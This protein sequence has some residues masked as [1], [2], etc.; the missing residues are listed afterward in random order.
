MEAQGRPR[1]RR[2]PATS[3]SGCTR[4][5]PTRRTTSRTRATSTSN[6][7]GTARG[8]VH[9]ADRSLG[10]RRRGVQEA[11]SG[12]RLG[13]TDPE[14]MQRCR[15]NDDER[16]PAGRGPAVLVRR[17]YVCELGDRRARR[18]P[19]RTRVLRWGRPAL[20]PLSTVA[21]VATEQRVVGAHLR[22]RPGPG[23]HA[24]RARRARAPR[25]HG[26]VLRARR[27]RRAA[28]GP[29]APH[30]RGGPRRRPARR[31][32]HPAQHAPG[33]RG[34]HPDPARPAAAGRRPRQAGHAV[35][36]GLRRPAAG[37]G[38]RHP[39]QRARDRAV[40]GVGPRLGGGDGGGGRRARARR[41][42]PRR[43]PAAARR[44]RRPGGDRRPGA[45][46][47]PRR[48]A[49][50]CCSPACATPATRRRR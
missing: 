3:S 13:A 10:K 31:G 6:P 39:G 28:P 22:R 26:D 1:R 24:R 34:G 14:T 49:R 8:D 9:A 20:L 29:A 16:R 33:A 5:S 41:R 25:R 48:G 7:L 2:Q 40:D 32:P 21:C 27:P 37:A 23:Q 35:P 45:G 43:V 12:D 30:R 18:C 44:D 47:R 11:R 17:G 4:S 15:G 19:S 38:G 50:G 46:V 36:P 42:P